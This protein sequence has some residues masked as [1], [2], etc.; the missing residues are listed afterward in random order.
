VAASPFV[1]TRCHRVLTAGG[2]IP[3]LA[4]RFAIID[5]MGFIA[6]AEQRG[7]AAQMFRRMYWDTAL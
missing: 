4:A 5:E 3:C 7:P 2:S 1:Q 6:G